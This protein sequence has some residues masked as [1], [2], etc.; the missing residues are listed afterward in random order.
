MRKCAARLAGASA[1]TVAALFQP[2]YV[3]RWIARRQPDFLFYVDTQEPL[4]AL[5]I[6][7]GPHPVVTLGILDA[8]R[9]YESHA[10]FFLIGER[11]PGNEGIVRRLV[12]EGHEIGNH[13]MADTPSIRLPAAELERQLL[14]AHDML[15]DFGPVRWFRPGSGWYNRRMLEQIERH[16]YRCVLGSA[17]AYEAHVRSV[18]YVSTHILLNVR[19]GSIIVLHDGT[20]DRA[21]TITVLRRLLPELQR[22]GYRVVTVSELVGSRHEG[23]G[24]MDG[25]R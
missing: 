6:D 15:S 17:Y 16:G 22:R 21:R 11:I 1:L 12:E 23:R 25:R 5:T 8:L 19:P 3:I 10:T 24:E 13:L 20:A 9:E 4:V 18:W 7:D 2:R 14:Q